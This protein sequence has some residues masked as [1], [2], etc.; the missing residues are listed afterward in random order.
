MS[1]IGMLESLTDLL[2]IPKNKS[3]KSIKVTDSTQGM[4]IW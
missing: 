4:W 3:K 1:I 2:C